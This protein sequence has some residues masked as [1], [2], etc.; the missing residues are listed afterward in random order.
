L[1]Q[2]AQSLFQLVDELLEWSRCQADGVEVELAA[3]Q[4]KP[5]IEDLQKLF[6]PL[7]ETKKIAFTCEIGAG[8]P[9]MIQSDELRLRQIVSNL[10]ANAIKFTDK[11][12]VALT[13][14]REPGT[15]CRLFFA[16]KDT[17]IGIPA[18]AMGRLFKPYMQADPSIAR[19]FGGSGLGLSISLHFAQLLGGRITVKSEQD[20]GSTFTLEI[21]AEPIGSAA[22]TAPGAPV[23]R[24]ATAGG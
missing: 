19:K 9:E 5:F 1:Q 4:V 8:V 15:P 21:V 13:V 20:K 7:A 23:D 11:G 10:V 3:I 16:V 17:G 12:A 18:A 6:R 14:E 24:S 22:S 2:S